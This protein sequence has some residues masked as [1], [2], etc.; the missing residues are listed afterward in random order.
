MKL[1]RLI[2]FNP[3][4]LKPDFLKQV[5]SERLLKIKT[6]TLLK[7]DTNEILIISYIPNQIIGT[8][9]YEII[10]TKT[11]YIRTENTL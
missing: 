5:N 4:L 7:K 2:I 10:Q 11:E 8:P 1:T 3:K 6:S 9:V